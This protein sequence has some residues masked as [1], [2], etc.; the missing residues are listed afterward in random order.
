[1]SCNRLILKT[2]ATIEIENVIAYYASI[3]ITLAK[4]L[5][6]EIRTGFNTISKNPAN[7]QCRYSK[8]RIF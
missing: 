8:V 4:R 2:T 5:E 7:F 1:M 6:K 3:N